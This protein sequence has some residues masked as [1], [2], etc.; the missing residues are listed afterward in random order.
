MPERGVSPDNAFLLCP[1]KR[2]AERI[3]Y[4]IC[5]DVTWSSFVVPGGVYRTKVK[6]AGLLKPTREPVGLRQAPKS[7]A[8][9]TAK[10]AQKPRKWAILA[11]P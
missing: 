3:P 10:L 9:F 5:I 11:P 2:K 6:P 1:H 4:H 7:D 8:R